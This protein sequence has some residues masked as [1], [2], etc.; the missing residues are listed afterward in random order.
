MQGSI[1]FSCI[2]FFALSLFS[3]NLWK[4]VRNI[5]LGKSKN[6]FNQPLKRTIILLKV[7]FGQ[8]KLF[9][10]PVSGILHALVFWGFLV[11]TIGTLEMMV[12]GVFGF[13]RLFG[14]LGSFYNLVTA[15]GDV[16]A[17]LVLVSCFIFMFRRR[18]MKIKRFSG[19]EMK[20]SSS[21]DAIVAL[22]IIVFLMISYCT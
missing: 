9:D 20:K 1:L 5:R 11:I 15:S 3:F 14:A 13:E 7:A 2:L 18:F 16:M 19:K 17:V 8:T 6:R 10:R 21:I 22:V 4:I 12:D